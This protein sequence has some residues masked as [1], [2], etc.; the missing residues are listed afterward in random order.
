MAA[1]FVWRGSG[2]ALG[3]AADWTEPGAGPGP[4]PV[5]PGTAD[6]ATLDLSAPLMATGTLDIA[7]L[8][9]DGTLALAAGAG[10]A[11]G[12][13]AVP[14]GAVAVGGTGTLAAAGRIDAPVSLAG[15]LAVG[16]ELALFAP[17]SGTGTLALAAGSTLFAAASL[18]PG[19]D[20]AFQG[21]GATL[22][23]F[24]DGAECAATLN[25]F[26]AGDA[27][28][29]A[30]ATLV[31]AA[32]A[33]GTLTLTGSDGGTL[34]L[35]L[36]GAFAAASF[37]ALP[38]GMDGSAVRLATPLPLPAS[39]GA[40]TLDG[41]YAG[42]GT[43]TAV[44]ALGTVGLAGTL[45]AASL[46]ASGMLAVLP[47]GTFTAGAM[48][49]AGG[50]LVQGAMA[51][52]GAAAGPGTLALA[53]AATLAGTG[54][55][56]AA[57]ANEG[58]MEAAGGALSLFGPVAGTGTLAI[59]AGAT[60]SLSAAV[61]AG[62]T[63][64]FAPSSTLLL[65]APAAFDAALT[66]LTPG[67][68]I[69]LCF[70]TPA[71]LP[72]A[73]ELAGVHVATAPD[74]A[75]G[76]LVTIIPCLVAGTRVATPGG[77]APVEML[78]PGDLVTTTDGPR[79]LCWTGHSVR[80]AAEVRPVRLAAGCLGPG[81]P[82][83]DL[84]LSPQHAVLHRRVLVPAVALLDLPGVSRE[85]PGPVAYHHLGLTRHGLVLADGAWV[86]TW[87]PHDPTVRFDREDGTR[88]PAGP[89][90]RPRLA[91]LLPP[92]SASALPP[93]TLRGHVER[94]AAAG[95]RTVL[96]GWA[97][98]ETAPRS[99][100]MLEVVRGGQTI[101]RLASNRWR[102]DL[103]RAGLGDG[104]CGFAAALP[105]PAADIAVRRQSD[106]YLLPFRSIP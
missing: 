14:A 32:W 93:G 60:L 42:D 55:I 7:R 104:R 39:A 81:R 36:P 100:V 72:I 25:G 34:A 26:A 64:A 8:V 33:A 106:G 91:A 38:D 12:G 18:G 79:R 48:G 101:A 59:A 77:E 71:G 61:A 102:A 45:H 103:D 44:T 6:A 68:A 56:T 97:L 4:A 105:G 30:D 98:D 43:A 10:I 11:V 13:A 35:A 85:Q 82:A 20:I 17:V 73:A 5:A 51:L 83:R 67:D 49:L 1:S 50:L 87:Q 37:I 47:Q 86:E 53:A 58:L 57:I 31:S 52:G 96:E 9:L 29:I 88:P 95:T 16:G 19:L 63:V 66:G 90:C 22:E 70:A 41:I 2:T 24:T 65:A 92:P 21:G 99:P 23:L 76:T 94:I 54:Q 89:P 74:G 69:D 75:G 3:T 15:Q 62:Q 78:R 28:D 40:L 46:A 84:R 80:A 27:V